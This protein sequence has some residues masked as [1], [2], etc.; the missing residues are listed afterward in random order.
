[1]CSE[2]LGLAAK[3]FCRLS[4]HVE[5]PTQSCCVAAD[6]ACCCLQGVA[7]REGD[8][9]P[10]WRQLAEARTRLQQAGGMWQKG[11]GELLAQWALLKKHNVGHAF[12]E[13]ADLLDM[14]G[15]FRRNR[16]ATA[17]LV[18]RQAAAVYG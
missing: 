11:L 16:E 18:G 12:D 1:M 3:M 7:G 4:L 9:L 8:M 6:A 5:S 14:N 17:G 2:Q 10:W 15:Y 13:L